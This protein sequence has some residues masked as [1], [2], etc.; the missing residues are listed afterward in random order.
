M[1]AGIGYWL[2]RKPAQTLGFLARIPWRFRPL[3][4]VPENLWSFL[5]AFELAR[6][7]KADGIQHIHSTW[8][9]GPATAAWVASQLAGIPFTFTGRAWDIFPADAWIREK[10]RDAAFVRSNTAAGIRHL[11]QYAGERSDRLR[12]TYN[13]M[14]LE[15][16]GDAHVAMQPP[17]RLLAIGRLVKKKGYDDLLRAAK[18]LADAGVPFDLTII[19]DGPEHNALRSLA[20]TLGLAGRV[21]F[22]GFQPHHLI[23]EHLC[24]SDIFVMPSVVDA[25]GNRDGIPNVIIEALAHRLPVVATDVSGIPEL[26]EDGVTG[27]LV[28]QKNP[29]ALAGAVRRLTADRAGALAIAERGQARVSDMFDAERNH[30]RLLDLYCELV[31]AR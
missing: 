31:P 26:I 19:G 14:P 17:Y 29:A 21:H 22:A 4:K 5:C 12:L 13:G 15:P 3:D 18:I 24:E 9:S 10:I 25:K 7:C 20:Q 23:G 16:A 2:V 1:A 6:R 27:L 11:T 8:A 30:C 28:P